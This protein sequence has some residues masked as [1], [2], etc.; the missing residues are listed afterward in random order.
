M[1]EIQMKHYERPVLVKMARLADITAG[2][3]FF[4]PA[5]FTSEPPPPP[6]PPDET[7]KDDGKDHDKDHDK[8]RDHGRH[9]GG[10]R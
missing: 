1:R 7:P 5:V 4:S 2:S 10:R 9:H 3:D 6:P 8:D